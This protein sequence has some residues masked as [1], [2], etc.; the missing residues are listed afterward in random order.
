[1][2]QEPFPGTFSPPCSSWVSLCRVSAFVQ[3]RVKQAS[4]G[5]ASKPGWGPGG[6][7]LAGAAVEVGLGWAV[8]AA[9]G[10]LSEEAAPLAGRPAQP[11]SRA[12]SS[13]AAVRAARARRASG[14]EKLF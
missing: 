9:A 7:I 10:L 12:A 2:T 5:S 1:M 3:I 6:Y 11:V 8:S 4:G 14:M 13:A